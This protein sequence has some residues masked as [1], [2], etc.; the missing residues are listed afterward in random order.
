KGRNVMISRSET[1]AG[2]VEK[3]KK[4]QEPKKAQK[5]Q[6]PK[7]KQEPKKTQEP[8][9]K[10]EPKKVQKTQEP[11][12]TG[13]T[14]K[15]QEKKTEKRKVSEVKKSD[16]PRKTLDSKKLSDSK[17]LIDPKKEEHRQKILA[18]DESWRKKVRNCVKDD[19]LSPVNYTVIYT[20]FA[21]CKDKQELNN[22]LTQKLPKEKVAD[23][24]AHIK[25]AFEEYVKKTD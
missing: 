18:L 21:T 23:V 24:Y 5:I 25:K 17:N 11:K 6:K 14:K 20:A 4:K 19:K 3:P 2:D 7:K 22:Q 15:K 12:K 10:Q 1:I 9:K 16:K 13:E 8:K